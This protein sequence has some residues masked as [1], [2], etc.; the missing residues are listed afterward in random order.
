MN[1]SQF[2]D[3]FT[4]NARHLMWF[5]G[6]GASRTAGM[7]TA[8]DLIWNLKRRYYCVQENQDW[9]GQAFCDSPVKPLFSI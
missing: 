1:D 7:P 9:S 6:A 5:L 3:Y 4:Q 8:N 2:I